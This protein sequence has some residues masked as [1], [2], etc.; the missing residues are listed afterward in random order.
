MIKQVKVNK[1]DRQIKVGLT[2]CKNDF[3]NFLR[4]IDETGTLAIYATV[5]GTGFMKNNFIGVSKCH[6]NDKWDENYGEMLAYHKAREKRDKSFFNAANRFANSIAEKINDSFNRIDTYGEKLY[7]NS[8][9]RRNKI[10]YH[11]K[12]C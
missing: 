2:D 7:S 10:E 8:K 12:N 9:Y 5:S 3:I 11:D 6:E 4:E 1:K